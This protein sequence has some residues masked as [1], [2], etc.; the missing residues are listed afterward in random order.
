MS[1]AKTKGSKNRI[2]GNN[3]NLNDESAK[4]TMLSEMRVSVRPPFIISSCTVYISWLFR[5]SVKCVRNLGRKI[6]RVSTK[7]Q[8]EYCS[9]FSIRKGSKAR[10]LS[11]FS[12]SSTN[13]DKLYNGWPLGAVKRWDIFWENWSLD[14]ELCSKGASTNQNGLE[15]TTARTVYFGI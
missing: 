2:G 9:S 12:E 1:K 14:G 4:E 10:W 6:G 7:H 5:I 8:K 15:T 13:E 3:R 11:V